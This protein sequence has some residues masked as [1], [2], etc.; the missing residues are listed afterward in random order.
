MK[1]RNIAFKFAVL[2]AVLAAGYAFGFAKGGGS[3]T[4]KGKPAGIAAMRMALAQKQA[5]VAELSAEIW[6]EER[7][8]NAGEEAG[9]RRVH[10][11]AEVPGGKE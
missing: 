10:G 5:E 4:A 6:L 8:L 2:A 1:T 3:R 9:C 7:H 11:D